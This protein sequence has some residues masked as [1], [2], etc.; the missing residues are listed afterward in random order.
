VWAADTAANTK[1]QIYGFVTGNSATTYTTDNAVNKLYTDNNAVINIKPA[2]GKAAYL[3]WKAK[4]FTCPDGNER[5]KD[6]ESCVNTKKCKDNEKDDYEWVAATADCPKDTTEAN[7]IT[8]I[9][10]G[11]TDQVIYG[12]VQADCPTG[13]TLKVVEKPKK[14]DGATAVVAGFAAVAATAALAF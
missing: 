6:A 7:K 3:D 1:V 8:C 12:S 13:Y 14:K 11:F 4:P 2:A 10:E 5:A 9:Q